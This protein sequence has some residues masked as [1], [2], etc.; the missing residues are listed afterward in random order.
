[1]SWDRHVNYP[2]SNGEFPWINRH[3]HI[4]PG[5]LKLLIYNSLFYSHINYCNSV[6][7]TVPSTNLKKYTSCKKRRALRAIEDVPFDF[8]TASLFR[9]FCVIISH[10]LFSY[11]LVTSL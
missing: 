4:L 1:M 10:A 7:G 8:H 9:K 6:W 2:I 5:N 3:R 11:R